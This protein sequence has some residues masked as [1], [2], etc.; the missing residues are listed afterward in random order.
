MSNRLT[1]WKNISDPEYRREWAEEHVGVGLAFQIRA[2]RESRGL[3]Q[4]GMGR[5]ANK[6]QGTISQWENPNYGRYS[7]SRLR[8]LAAAFDV[9]LLVRFVPFSELVDWTA[10]LTPERSAP[11]PFEA[12]EGFTLTEMEPETPS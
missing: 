5:L 6:A 1:I 8:E 10:G 7:L 4:E 12:D 9:G 3:T 11:P 2:L